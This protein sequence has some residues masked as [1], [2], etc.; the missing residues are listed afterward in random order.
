MLNYWLFFVTNKCDYL[1]NSF[2]ISA[3]VTNVIAF[4]IPNR[5]CKT[6]QAYRDVVSISRT[7]EFISSI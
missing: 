1:K 4:L 7:E 2:N 3:K 6:V 5:D